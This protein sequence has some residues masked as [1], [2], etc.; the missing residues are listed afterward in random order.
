ML[1]AVLLFLKRHLKAG[2]KVRNKMSLLNNITLPKAA[3]RSL[4][5]LFFPKII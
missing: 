3:V 1:Q 5:T 2:V 4:E